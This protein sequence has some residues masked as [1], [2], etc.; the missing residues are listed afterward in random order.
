MKHDLRSSMKFWNPC[1]V[2]ICLDSSVWFRYL[3]FLNDCWW[4]ASLSYKLFISQSS[5][6]TSSLCHCFS[7]WLDIQHL[8]FCF[9]HPTD[10]RFHW[11]SCKGWLVG[12]RCGHLGLHD[13]LIV[14]IHDRFHISHAPVGRF[15]PG[16]RT[17]G[18]SQHHFKW[19]VSSGWLHEKWN[20][21]RKH[22]QFTE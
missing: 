18:G 5:L 20:K 6:H 10:N 2:Q 13:F 8:L 7:R 22:T 14:G 15:K 12:D 21:R 4:S 19:R 9:F 16:A 3:S 17:T 1:C 11:F